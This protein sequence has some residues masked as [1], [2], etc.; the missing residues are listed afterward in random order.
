MARRA[1]FWDMVS[2]IYTADPDTHL[3][4]KEWGGTTLWEGAVKDIPYIPFEGPGYTVAS[5]RARI[6]E[7][8]G[9]IQYYTV[10][11]VRLKERA[12]EQA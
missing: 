9:E 2:P 4:V 7:D 3:I 11:V 5:I 8:M 10:E 12:A 6:E 1:S